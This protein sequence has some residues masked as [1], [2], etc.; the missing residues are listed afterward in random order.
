[1]NNEVLT[2]EV[3]SSEFLQI[4]KIHLSL[5]AY[6][7]NA[8]FGF[9]LKVEGLFFEYISNGNQKKKNQKQR[10]VISRIKLNQK[11]R[12]FKKFKNPHWEL[13]PISQIIN[14]VR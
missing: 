10:Q 8:R 7:S 6:A 13:L 2:F 12:Y 3:P 11:L 14:I 5:Q 4:V 9:I 1:M